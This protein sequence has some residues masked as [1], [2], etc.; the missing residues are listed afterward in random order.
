MPPVL[1]QIRKD[2]YAWNSSSIPWFGCVNTLIMDTLR[3]LLYLFQTIPITVLKGFF[4]S[5]RSMSILFVWHQGHSRIRH[6]LLTYP[7]LQRGVGLPDFELYHRAALLARVLEWFPRPFPKESTMVQQD[8]SD[9]DFDLRA[10]LWGFGQ[11]LQ[12]L[13]SSS[14]LTIAA[15][16]LWYR[17]GM[18]SLLSTDSSP[19]TSQFDHPTLSQDMGLHM[20]GP[21]T[22]SSWPVA[23]SFVHPTSGTPT[24]P[25]GR[26]NWLTAL[27]ISSFCSNVS[28]SS[29]GAS[30]GAIVNHSQ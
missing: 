8:L 15:L 29:A 10:L 7:K 13:S 4:S 24:V 28:S 27:C 11:E 14:P 22:C 30:A 21:F 5:L 3:K 12:R 19:L 17:M 2:L 9:F 26:G 6:T 20:V 23:S 18:S 16:R 1:S 25:E